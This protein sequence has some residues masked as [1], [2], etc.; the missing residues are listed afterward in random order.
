[1][2]SPEPTSRLALIGPDAS[3]TA[4]VE[5]WARSRD[6]FSQFFPLHPVAP[7]ERFGAFDWVLIGAD[8]HEAIAIAECARLR[9]A[10]PTLS[11]ALWTE[12]ADELAAA[13]ERAGA[14]CV[15]ARTKPTGL[16]AQ[17]LERLAERAKRRRCACPTF[18]DRVSIDRR[19]R[20][21]LVDGK[22]RAL[23]AEKFDLLC[24]FVDH[25]G[26]AISAQELVR[27][28]L[29]LPNQA[30]RYR[31]LILE[32]RRL[33]AIGDAWI[34]AVPGYGYRAALTCSK[35]VADCIETRGQPCDRGSSLES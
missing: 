1:M 9:H 34:R 33:L 30:V 21:V 10:H 13:A 5:A 3:F 7:A 35:G 15:L 31:G 8:P 27:E 12:R 26:R 20:T 29:L 19:S 24:Y 32:L 25:A 16:S 17:G 23:R 4:S 28:R 2:S 6:I 11:L 22:V 14:T 18:A